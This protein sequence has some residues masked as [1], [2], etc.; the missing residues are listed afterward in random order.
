MGIR[1]SGGC[2]YF[3]ANGDMGDNFKRRNARFDGYLFPARNLVGWEAR[4][5]WADLSS[6][7]KLNGPEITS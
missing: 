5:L 1:A 6:M 2:R 3:R 7:R 4:K